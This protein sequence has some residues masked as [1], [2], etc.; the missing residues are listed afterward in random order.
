MVAALPVA[1]SRW[2]REALQ[3]R[4]VAAAL[5]WAVLVWTSA[6]SQWRSPPW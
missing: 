6:L 5:P 1:A 2:E 4:S 3:W